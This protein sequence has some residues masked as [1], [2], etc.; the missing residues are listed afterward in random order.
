MQLLNEHFLAVHDVDALLQLL[1][2]LT[3]EVEDASHDGLN[4][5]LFALDFVDANRNA[6]DEVVVEAS[7]FVEEHLVVILERNG[8]RVFVDVLVP[9]DNRLRSVE[10]VAN[11]A[12]HQ[13]LLGHLGRSFTT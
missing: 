4:L 5:R 1:E 9:V 11:L 8:I 6:V 3:G 13:L 7:F 12:A 10:L 2:T